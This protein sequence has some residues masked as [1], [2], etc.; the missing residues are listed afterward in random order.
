MGPNP[1]SW[2]TG[3]ADIPGSMT[4]GTAAP[5][6]LVDRATGSTVTVTAENGADEGR[7]MLVDDTSMTK[8][9]A[10]ANTA[11][12][13]CQLTAAATVKQY[14]LTSADDV[15][16]RD[17]KNWVLQGSNDGV[18]WTTVDTR[19][20]IDFVDRR[21]T[22]AFVVPNTTAY[23]RYRLQVTANHGAAETQLAEFEL[24]A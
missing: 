19:T 14:T 16:G 20:N 12:I 21:Q 10:F 5:V 18:T 11:T 1:S 13:T 4:T 15:P 9:L 22:R 23:C 8:W 7:A 3:A 2:G 24:L 17:P 6:Q